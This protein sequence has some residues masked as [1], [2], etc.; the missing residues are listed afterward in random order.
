[1]LLLQYFFERRI[2]MSRNG[3]KYKWFVY[4]KGDANTNEVVSRML[5][6]ETTSLVLCAD[7][8]RRYLWGCTHAF[9]TEL[10]KSKEQFN[11]TFDVYV[12]EGEG[13]VRLWALK[14][15]MAKKDRLLKKIRGG[16]RPGTPR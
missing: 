13:K 7:G 3:R 16:E 12:A 6:G 10:W 15:E 5:P 8:A 1:M 14:N 4:T 9:I 2:E 11:L